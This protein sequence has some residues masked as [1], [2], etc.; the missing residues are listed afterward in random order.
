MNEYSALD[1]DIEKMLFA[2]ADGS[3]AQQ[4]KRTLQS[5]SQA[6]KENTMAGLTASEFMK[7]RNLQKAGDTAAA[8]ITQIRAQLQS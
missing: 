3:F 2:D 1:S 4:L 7:W 5:F 8:S 6:V